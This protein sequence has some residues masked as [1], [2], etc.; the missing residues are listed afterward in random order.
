LMIGPIVFS[1]TDVLDAMR[2]GHIIRS[3]ARPYCSQ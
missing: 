1:R 3:F 2:A